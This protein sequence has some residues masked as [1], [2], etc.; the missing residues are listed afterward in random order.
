[1][2][3]GMEWNVMK[4]YIGDSSPTGPFR[5]IVYVIV[6]AIIIVIVIVKVVVI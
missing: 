6:I 1:M 2:A 3:T 4:V 5:P